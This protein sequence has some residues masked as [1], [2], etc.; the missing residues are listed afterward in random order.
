MTAWEHLA[1]NRESLVGDFPRCRAV[2]NRAAFTWPDSAV[3]P[4]V[5]TITGSITTKRTGAAATSD[6]L[7]ASF[8]GA[9]ADD[10]G[11]PKNSKTP[12]PI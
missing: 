12:N 8:S 3:T 6:P 5:I 2:P 4:E 10:P 1:T 9:W 7:V 11:H